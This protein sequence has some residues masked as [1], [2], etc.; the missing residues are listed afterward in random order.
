MNNIDYHTHDLELNF[1]NQTLLTDG[2]E[3]G[4]TFE[5][6]PDNIGITFFIDEYIENFTWHYNV[7]N[8][9]EFE[10]EIREGSVFVNHDFNKY[11]QDIFKAT[12]Y[13]KQSHSHFIFNLN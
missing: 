10:V 6:A 13:L 7:L 2:K 12:T 3:D 9:T 1:L 11:P 5:I 4:F 8:I